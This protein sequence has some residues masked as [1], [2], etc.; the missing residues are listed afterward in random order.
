MG[1][2]VRTAASVVA[3][4]ILAAACA[5]RTPSVPPVAVASPSGLP[6]SVQ[7]VCDSNGTTV[8]TP[9]V[10]PQRDGVHLQIQNTTGK[11]LSFVVG[12]DGDDAPA[13]SSELIW[14]LPPGSVKIG[15]LDDAQDGGTPPGGEVTVQDPDG[16]WVDAGAG[17]D[18]VANG[19]FDYA[20]GASGQQGTGRHREAPISAIASRTGDIV[21]AAGYPDEPNGT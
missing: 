14:P 8:L 13:G 10:R 21:K 19:I 16:I 18:S 2:I 5:G 17:C 4:V 1:R 20:E 9:V 15:C 7:V 11:H 6:D 12:E 3:T